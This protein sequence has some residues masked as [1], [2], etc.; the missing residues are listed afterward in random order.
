MNGMPEVLGNGIISC[1]EADKERKLRIG[2]TTSHVETRHKH[3]I[4]T[5]HFIVTAEFKGTIDYSRDCVVC[6]SCKPL[7]SQ[8]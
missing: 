5:L 1:F 6:I 7:S 4:S 2:L 3:M 8:K